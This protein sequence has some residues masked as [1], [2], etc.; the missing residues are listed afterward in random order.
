MDILLRAFQNP[1]LCDTFSKG[2]GLIALQV[3]TSSV[4]C[5]DTGLE[6]SLKVVV[7]IDPISHRIG[8]FE[9]DLNVLLPFNL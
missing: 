7:W 5:A 1:S 6:T 3:Q 4:S 2:E 8:G 9:K